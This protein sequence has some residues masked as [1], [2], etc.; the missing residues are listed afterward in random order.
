MKCFILHL[1][2]FIF[3]LAGSARADGGD[4]LDR[5]VR[6]PGMK[7]TVYALLGKVSE[8][9]GYL[10][11]YD[12]KVIHNDSVVRVRKQECSVRQAIHRITGSRNLELKVLGNH[13]LIT[14]AA[15]RKS[16][17]ETVPLPPRPAYSTIAGILLDKETGE[18]VVSAS[19]I[20]QGTSLGNITN[21]NGEF[22]LNLPDSLRRCMLSFSHLGYVGQTVEASALEGRSN[23]LSLEPKVISLQEVLIRLVEPKKLLREMIE[24]RDRNCSTSPVYLTTFYREGVQLKNKFQSLTEAVF[25]VYKSPTMEPGQ[26]DQVKLLKMS[27]IDNREQTDSVLAKISSGVEACLQLDI[28]KNLPDFLLLESGEELYTY[29][30]GD[31]VSVDDRTA[32]VVYF[33]QKRGVKE[34]LFCGELYIDS[35]NS[36]LLRARFEIHPRYVKAATRLFVIRQAPKI[37]LTTEKLVYTVSYKPWNGTYYVHHIR[38]DLYFKMKR[39]RM[40]FSNPTLYTWFEMVTCRIDGENVTRFPRA[41]RLPVHTV[42]SETDFTRRT[43]SDSRKMVRPRLIMKLVSAVV[44]ATKAVRTMPSFISRSLARKFVRLRR[45]ARTSM[46]WSI[47]TSLNVY[48]AVNV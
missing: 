15:E 25:K 33:E 4:V 17:E 8:Q 20:A 42:F 7:G 31:I 16:M 36:A 5:I 44:N 32:N 29:T 43:L 14:R 47:S 12:S 27:K 34:P 41:E 9:S 26:K 21:Q 28:M 6:L 18:P 45:S 23:V 24:H 13:I 40:L 11:I 19:V 38:G 1:P 37:R 39:K 48:I 35:E 46:G 10:F 2:L 22:R 30:S 3:F